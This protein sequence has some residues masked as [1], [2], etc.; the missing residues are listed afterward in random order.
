MHRSETMSPQYSDCLY[1]GGWQG[2]QAA[3]M[4]MCVCL[5]QYL[6][7]RGEILKPNVSGGSYLRP[8]SKT[9]S[10]TAPKW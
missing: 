7:G 5:C 10:A 1:S 4:C 3:Y 6:T 2:R 9:Q 8:D